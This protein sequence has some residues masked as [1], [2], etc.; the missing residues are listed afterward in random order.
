MSTHSTYHQKKHDISWPQS[1]SLSGTNAMYTTWTG[2]WCIQTS[3][4]P[5][6]IKCWN[7]AKHDTTS[8]TLET[9]HT[10]SNP[11]MTE[12]SCHD[13]WHVNPHNHLTLGWQNLGRITL[14]ELLFEESPASW[15]MD[16][17]R[18]WIW[19]YE[20]N[21]HDEKDEKEANA[22]VI[23][24]LINTTNQGE[25]HVSSLISNGTVTLKSMSTET[26]L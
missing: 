18:T 26:A 19:H 14:S 20:D 22:S 7:H 24:K 2:R 10:F 11:R 15:T 13:V 8:N 25:Y 4:V 16:S 9:G 23:Q 21:Q 17:S 3:W 6:W 5:P 1:T 12:N